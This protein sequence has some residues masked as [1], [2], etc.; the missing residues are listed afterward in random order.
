MIVQYIY[1]N[2]ILKS[3]EKKKLRGNAN[4]RGLILERLVNT[5]GHMVVR[6]NLLVGIK[7]RLSFGKF[8]IIAS[9]AVKFVHSTISFV[10]LYLETR[11]TQLECAMESFVF[12]HKSS[13]SILFQ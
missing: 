12:E 11:D 9:P 2:G 1:E 13:T 6:F 3:E 7:L 5:H 8:L 10:Q 4:W